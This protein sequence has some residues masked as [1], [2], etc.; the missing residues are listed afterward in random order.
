[1]LQKAG[2]NIFNIPADMVFIDLLTDSGTSAMSDRQW[3]GM[4][5]GDESY[6]GAKSFFRFEKT[7]KNIFGFKHVIPTHQGRAAE[8]I[9]FQTVV[10]EGD[11][12]PNNIHFD[13]TGAN[14]SVLKAHPLN[15]A[16]DSAYEVSIDEP[17]KGN[18]DVKKLETF[19]HE[20]GL[21]SIPLVMLTVTNNSAAGQ[22][23]SMENIKKVSTLC[24]EH[25]LPLFLDAARFAENSY[26]IK[27]REEGYAGKSLLEIARE[28]FSY[29]DGATMSA[30]KDALVNIGGFITLNDTALAHKIKNNL[31]VGEGFPTY[32]GLAGRDLEAV[33]QG[34][35]EV[36]EEDYMEHRISQVRYF[37]KLL[38][39][40][41][42]PIYK[43]TGGHAV[44]ILADKFLSHIPREQFPG[45]ALTVALYREAGVRGVEIGG[46]MFA[47][48][49]EKSG[50]EIF[51]KLE[52]VRLSLPRR[53]YTISHIRYVVDALTEIY[54]KRG[55]IRGFKIVEEEPPLRHFT[56]RFE[57]I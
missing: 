23:V 14:I 18:M 17:F 5:M 44:Y 46:V 19:L 39:E 16:V 34:L 29:A 32:G 13:T 3:A 53:V 27:T 57:E 50:K 4:I 15:F 24:R 1:V 41:G 42:I 43:P 47:Q 12:V 11:S 22:P 55:D 33:S 9:L 25:N 45:W 20:N 10:N 31:I 21:E 36:L 49:D 54:K 7:I 35:E 2:F 48:K 8:R 26:F 52:M 56:A 28:M 38:D 40:A 6:A 51:P 30:K 37:G